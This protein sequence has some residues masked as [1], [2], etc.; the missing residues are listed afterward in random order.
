[1]CAEANEAWNIM[2][3]MVWHVS[4]PENRVL[5]G[6]QRLGAFFADSF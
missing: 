2:L 1:L 4:V 6:D 3:G 5:N